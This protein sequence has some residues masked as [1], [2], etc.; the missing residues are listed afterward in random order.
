MAEQSHDQ[1]RARPRQRTVSAIAVIAPP[2][3]VLAA[4]IG[5]WY[6]EHYRQA[7]IRRFIWPKPHEIIERGFFESA[8]LST[9]LAALWESTKVAAI[10]WRSR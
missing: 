9:I 5:A 1:R 2:L 10:G 3:V 6:V 4:L 7:P 8:N